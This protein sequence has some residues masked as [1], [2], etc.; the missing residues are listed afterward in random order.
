MHVCVYHDGDLYSVQTVNDPTAAKAA[1]AQKANRMVENGWSLVEVQ[2]GVWLGTD[3]HG[4]GVAVV[5]GSKP[6]LYVIQEAKRRKVDR[7]VHGSAE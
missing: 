6:Q 1:A 7:M 2:S 5:A 3:A 4:Y